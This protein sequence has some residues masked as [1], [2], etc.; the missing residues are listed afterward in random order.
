MSVSKAAVLHTCLCVTVRIHVYPGKQIVVWDVCTHVSA[1]AYSFSPT[2]FVAASHWK[3]GF[4][5]A[6]WACS[7][8]V[9]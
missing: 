7:S 6:S 1:A 9:C 5:E 4:G 8:P 2:A 3:E